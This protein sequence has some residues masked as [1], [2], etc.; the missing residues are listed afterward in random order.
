VTLDRRVLRKSACTIALG[1]SLAISATA[2]SQASPAA[3]GDV[4]RSR[5][6]IDNFGRVNAGY[7]RGAQ[8]EGGD[9]AD[10]AAFG[11][12]TVIDLTQDGDAQESALVQSAGMK[13]YRIPMTTHQ[14]P[15]SEKIGQFLA[16]VN[17][18]ANQPVYVHCQGG[19]HRTGVM[20]A[21]YRMTN[22][23]W[24]ADRAFAEMK[25]YKFGPDF[26]HSEFKEFVYAY[27]VD[28]SGTVPTRVVAGAKVGSSQP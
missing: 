11:I 3:A 2:E 22:D 20:T 18:P 15:S 10:L 26:L 7:Y 13:F 4:N 19:R 9:Y 12:R 5:V 27:H 24:T 23:G 8:P 17:D 14:T 1:L 16:L 21:I 25:Q 6:A 28:A